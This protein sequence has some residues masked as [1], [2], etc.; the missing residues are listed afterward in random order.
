MYRMEWVPG[1]VLLALVVVLPLAPA[2]AMIGV[3]I[4]AL[5]AL[6]A[7]VAL[8]AAVVASPFLLARTVRHRLAERQESPHGAV[9]I[10]AVAVE[11]S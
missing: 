11:P 1:T 5:G 9:Q 7:I 3:L 8:A 4:L 10:P 6:A 2:F